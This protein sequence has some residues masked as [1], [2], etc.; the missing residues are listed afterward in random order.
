[1]DLEGISMG[2]LTRTCPKWL[3]ERVLSQELIMR[4]LR[5]EY[6]HKLCIL[7]VLPLAVIPRGLYSIGV[8]GRENFLDLLAVGN[9]G[10]TQL[11]RGAN[12]VQSELYSPT[13]LK[14]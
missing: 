10:T 4:L 3:R 5:L 2:L 13:V 11:K 8:E 7:R 9:R 12:P 14:P 6:V 1:M